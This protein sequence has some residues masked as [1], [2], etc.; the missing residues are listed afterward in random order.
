F[1]EQNM[2]RGATV[3]RGLK[4]ASGEITGFMD[5]DC[6][7]AEYYIAEF[8]RRISVGFDLA[9][10]QRVYR[11]TPHPYVI[12]RHVLSTI[13]KFFLKKI[14]GCSAEDTEAGFKFFSRNF[15][16]TILKYSKFDDWFW[17]TE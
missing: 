6:E 8:V 17:D 2:G 7:V 10:G 14:I 15:V 3:K 12:I 1:N 9:V 16:Q 5:I 4:M 13:Y 11:V